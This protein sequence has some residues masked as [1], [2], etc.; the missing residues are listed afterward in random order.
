M[1][2]MRPLA[3]ALVLTAIIC[4]QAPSDTSGSIE[5]KVVNLRGEPLPKTTV[6]LRQMRPG[7]PERSASTDNNGQFVFEGVA[8]APYRLSAQHAGYLGAPGIGGATTLDIHA[9]SRISDLVIAMTPQGIIGG[10][11]TD[12]DGDLVT[13]VRVSAYQIH[14][15]DHA[16]YVDM[17]GVATM[18]PDGTFMVGNLMPGRYYLG[19]SGRDRLTTYFPDAT[20]LSASSPIEV[21]PGADIRGIDVRVRK[22]TGFAISGKVTGAAGP[23]VML[24]LI[25]IGLGPPR[26]I[27][28]DTRVNTSGSFAIPNVPAG[29]YVFVANTEWKGDG[30]SLVGYV[31]FTLSDHDLT[32]VSIPLGPGLKVSGTVRMEDGSAPAKP[33]SINL[34][35][36]DPLIGG[37]GDVADAKGKFEI[38][39]LFPERHR[40]EALS[41]GTYV[42]SVRFAGREI[43]PARSKSC[44]RRR[45]PRSPV[46]SAIRTA[47][48]F[49][50][51]SSSCG[52]ICDR[53][54]PRHKPPIAPAAS[55][56]PISHREIT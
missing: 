12:E 16:R 5:G 29:S 38:E 54:C 4:A 32:G 20:D 17:Q 9:G 48:P 30:A 19:A 51:C 22:G 39:G 26:L 8:P 1:N 7:F 37:G 3:L 27:S 25:S 33:A 50:S 31:P 36:S 46:L 41:S 11:L 34:M 14:W 6:T 18:N 55:H 28:P 43:A 23:S 10:K 40:I 56:F 44:S 52:R 53:T 13:G 49:R 15:F 45:Q 47:N 24:R 35:D 2:P 21:T 42:K